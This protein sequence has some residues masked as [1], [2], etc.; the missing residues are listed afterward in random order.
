[1]FLR[2][3]ISVGD[4][5]SGRALLE[6]EKAAPPAIDASFSSV[7]VICWAVATVRGEDTT[8]ARQTKA[9]TTNGTGPCCFWRFW[10][11]L[12]SLRILDRNVVFLDSKRIS[13]TKCMIIGDASR[14]RDS[15]N[16]R[17]SLARIV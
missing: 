11:S 7:A 17:R 13:V 5:G 15:L 1:V 12:A 14:A 10:N 16:G 2:V 4:D 6:G 3:D 8:M 9:W